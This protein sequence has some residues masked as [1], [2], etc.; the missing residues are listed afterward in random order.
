M[1]STSG[2]RTS[3]RAATLAGRATY[4]IDVA[5]H[6][7]SHWSDWLGDVALV[8]NDDATTTLTV[9]VADQ[10]QLHGVVAGV[11]DLG[12]TLL[13]L[14]TVDETPD[15]GVESAPVLAHCL[16]TD[17]LTLRPATAA[18]A[19]ATWA[20]RRLDSVNEWLGGVPAGVEDYRAMFTAPSRLATTVIVELDGRHGGAVV[21]DLMLRRED[22]WSQAEVVDQA[23]GAQAE[24]GWVLDP[25]HTGAGFATEAVRELLRYCFEELGVHRV[26]ANCFLDNDTSW[27]LMERVGMRREAHAVAE[28]R[29]RS[30]RWLDTVGYAVLEE[31]WRGRPDPRR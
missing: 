26:T 8:R 16:H 12:V 7:D 28:S 29:H 2:I 18:D 13:S 6:L 10:A 17:R 30:G 11:R 9:R 21:G 24:L 22:A 27:R 25:V 23:R 20:Y 31:E 15:E 3:P 4:R 19:D 14:R 1:N 5:G